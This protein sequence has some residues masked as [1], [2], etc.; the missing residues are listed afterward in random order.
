MTNVLLRRAALALALT[1][2]L[3]AC[4]K[5]EP[6]KA[7]EAAAQPAKPAAA[8][9]PAD[10]GRNDAQV[11]PATNQA[12]LVVSDLEAYARGMRQEIALLK[13]AGDKVAQARAG[14]NQEAEAAAMMEMAT[15]DTD[16]EGGKVSGL[17]QARYL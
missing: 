17:P 13:A 7:P 6:T 1:T 5:D 2:V 10:D 3:A 12:P 9:A 14:K 11:Q 8:N 15:L 16:L 4:G